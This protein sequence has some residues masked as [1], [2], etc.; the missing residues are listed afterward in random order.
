MKNCKLIGLATAA[1]ISAIAVPQL[2][3][4][5]IISAVGVTASNSYPDPTFGTANNLINQGGLFTGYVSGV[6]NFDAYIAGNPQHT[7]ISI[8]A[9][10]FTNSG[11]SSATLTFDLGSVMTIDRVATWVDEFW[12]AGL[13][14]VSLSLDGVS[15][16]SVGSYSPTDWATSVSSYGADIFA[17]S[18]TS[19]RYVQLGLSNCPQPLSQAGGGC[20]MGE[21]A[22]ATAAVPEPSS[23]ALAG[24][25]LAAL[26]AFRRR[27]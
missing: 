23:L 15:F 5:A 16:G 1:F 19:A 3:H 17:F 25:G 8:G 24:L 6:T 10:W 27:Q 4:A 9:E 18:A 21:V 11:V 20:G 26:V 7:P 2:A 22:F 12:G 14:A 13:I